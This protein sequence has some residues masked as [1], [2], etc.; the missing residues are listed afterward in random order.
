M[1][2]GISPQELAFAKSSFIGSQA[3]SL[4]TNGGMASSLSNIE[5]YGLGLDFWSRYPQL[6][7]GVTLE[8]ANEAARQLIAPAKAH[9]IIVGPYEEK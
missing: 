6:I 5:F 9:V 8:Q 1:K 3:R 4:A 2:A 7:Q